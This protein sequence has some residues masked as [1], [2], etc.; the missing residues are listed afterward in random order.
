[1]AK[2]KNC[3]KTIDVVRYL[4][5]FP[6]ATVVT[7]F[8]LSLDNGDLFYRRKN[9]GSADSRYSWRFI[10]RSSPLPSLLPPLGF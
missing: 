1:M 3:L 7:A 10:R 9:Q 4:D 5:P 8:P 6:S 2:Y